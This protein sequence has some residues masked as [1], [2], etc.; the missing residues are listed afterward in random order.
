[1]QPM[2]PPDYKSCTRSRQQTRSEA[3]ALGTPSTLQRSHRI[4]LEDSLRLPSNRELRHRVRTLLRRGARRIVLDLAAVSTIDAAGIG[5]LVR[6]YN[7]AIGSHAALRIV[8]TTP[9]VHEMLERVRLF[10]RL[11]GRIE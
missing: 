11:T 5:E 7:K 2:T 1:M 4:R 8:N 9:R 10:N 6:V 3:F